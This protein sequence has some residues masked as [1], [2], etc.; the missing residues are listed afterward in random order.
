MSVVVSF[1]SFAGICTMLCGNLCPLWTPNTIFQVPVIIIVIMIYY[2]NWQHKL[3]QFP[4]LWLYGSTLDS[5]L[6]TIGPL[7]FNAR[8]CY[9]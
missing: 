4:L 1:T 3:K 7:R 9:R 2:T 6:L 8:C 5:A